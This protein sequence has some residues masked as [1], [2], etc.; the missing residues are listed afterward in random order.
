MW[1]SLL[2]PC[3]YWSYWYWHISKVTDLIDDFNDSTN[4]TDDTSDITNTADDITDITNTTDGIRDIADI[5]DLDDIT[6]LLTLL[7]NQN[8]L[9]NKITD[10]IG[11]VIN[12]KT[13]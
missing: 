2:I 4:V 10:V 9:F 6:D 5:N 7:I 12:F 11:F 13:L 8:N 3:F 1:L